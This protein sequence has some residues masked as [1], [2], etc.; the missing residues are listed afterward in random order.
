MAMPVGL[1][2]TSTGA[3]GRSSGMRLMPGLM[4]LRYGLKAMLGL[5]AKEGVTGNDVWMRD[6]KT[7]RDNKAMLS[8]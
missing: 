7:T 6:T 1:P 5:L 2:G 8:S 4:W 3:L